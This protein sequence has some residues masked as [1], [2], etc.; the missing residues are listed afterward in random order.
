MKCKFNFKIIRHNGE[1]ID[2]S[3]W[4]VWVESFH[5]FSPEMNIESEKADGFDGL[6]VLDVEI[7]ERRMSASIQLSEDCPKKFDYLLDFVRDKFNPKHPITII[8]DLQ[9]G[10]QIKAYVSGGYGVDYQTP[11]DGDLPLEFTAMYPYFESVNIIHRAYTTLTF[12]FKNEGNVPIDMRHQSDTTITFKGASNGLTIK[13]LTTGDE[14]KYNGTTTSSDEIKLIG[15]RSLKNGQSIFGDSNHKLI[16]FAPGN[17]KFEISG[18]SG[19]FELNIAT[20]FYFL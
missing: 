17:N 2:L 3:H 6:E 19:A 14:W 4:G 10:K 8:R 16:S 7:N 5:I 13:N 18:T 9:P 1:V 11:E 20:R 12:T 15:V